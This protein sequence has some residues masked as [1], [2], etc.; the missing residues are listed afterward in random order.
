VDSR[1]QLLVFGC[2]AGEKKLQGFV[3][4]P[5]GLKP[6]SLLAFGGTAEAVPFPE[7]PE[8]FRAHDELV[9]SACLFLGF[10]SSCSRHGFL[11]LHISLDFH[12]VHPAHYAT[13]GF[14]SS[15]ALALAKPEWPLH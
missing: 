11:L 1:F 4:L 9:L 14:E 3:N 5:Q 15:P 8:F 7:L 2:R 6:A 12:R 13:V 10:N